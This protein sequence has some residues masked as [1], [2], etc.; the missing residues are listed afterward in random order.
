MFKIVMLP[1]HLLMQILFL[2]Q[3]INSVSNMSGQV[4]LRVVGQGWITWGA[5]GYVASLRMLWIFTACSAGV[6]VQCLTSLEKTLLCHSF[7]KKLAYTTRLAPTLTIPQPQPHQTR[8][9]PHAILLGIGVL[10][11][12]NVVFVKL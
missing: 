7:W 1:M 3:V 10:G 2:N 5:V 6:L 8:N 12:T 11:Q 4:F 9:T